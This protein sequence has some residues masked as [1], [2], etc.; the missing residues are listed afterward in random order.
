MI[1]QKEPHG[2]HSTYRPRSL[3]RQSALTSTPSCFVFENIYDVINDIQWNSKNRNR[4]NFQKILILVCSTQSTLFCIEKESLYGVGMF[5]Q[6]LNSY[7]SVKIKQ[8]GHLNIYQQLSTK[9]FVITQ[10]VQ[11]LKMISQF[12]INFYWQFM[13]T[14]GLC[15][16]RD[17]FK[18]LDITKQ[19][20]T[21]S[22]LKF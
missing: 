17:I 6:N 20:N 1:P 22:L 3:G 4:I 11:Q 9:L 19:K 5:S 14:I 10:Y 16:F 7:F 8:W 15:E 21:F 13:L 2:G 12:Y 18:K